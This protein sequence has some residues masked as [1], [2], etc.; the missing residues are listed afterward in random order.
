MPE[1]GTIVTG[2]LAAAAMDADA[3]GCDG[4]VSGF[5]GSFEQPAAAAIPTAIPTLQRF[6]L[7]L[8]APSVL[9]MYPNGAHVTR[10][11]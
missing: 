10:N 2:V 9:R 11:Q 5:G 6:M 1:V 3:C 4:F 7:R 8:L